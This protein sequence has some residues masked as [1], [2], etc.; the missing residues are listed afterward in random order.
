MADGQKKRM[1]LFAVTE[2]EGSEKSWWTKIGAAFEN[3]D[4]SWSLIFDAFP[5]NGRAQM[6]EP[7][8]EE[9]HDQGRQEQDPG[10]RP[11]AGRSARGAR[12]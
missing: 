1:E 9:P 2:R 3:R 10:P 6:R 8:V 12:R 7:Y 4:G 5:T 11:Q